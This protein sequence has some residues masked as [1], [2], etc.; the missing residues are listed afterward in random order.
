MLAMDE[1]IH[2]KKEGSHQKAVRRLLKRVSVV[3][4]NSGLNRS[5]PK[6]RGFLSRG[7]LGMLSKIQQ[8]YNGICSS[9]VNSK[10]RAHTFC[11]HLG[12]I[13]FSFQPTLGNHK[14]QPA[15]AS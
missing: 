3:K 5:R 15:K 11:A 14:Q 10:V 6:S 7:F 9:H 8:V 2:Y 12:A 4:K 1:K 13:E